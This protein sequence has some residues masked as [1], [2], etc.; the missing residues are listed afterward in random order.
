MVRAVGRASNERFLGRMDG[1]VG[2]GQAVATADGRSCA[3]DLVLARRGTSTG[4]AVSGTL[5]RPAAQFWSF[6]ARHP[7]GRRVRPST[8]VVN[9]SELSA[10]MRDVHRGPVAYGVADAISRD[11]H[12]VQLT[13]WLLNEILVLVSVHVPPGLADPATHAALQRGVRTAT[14]QALDDAKAVLPFQAVL[15]AYGAA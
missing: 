5:T 12:F 7:D 4:A 11:V 8:V 14:T 1:R 2:V 6:V 3:V 9:Q 10:D 13:E 15:P